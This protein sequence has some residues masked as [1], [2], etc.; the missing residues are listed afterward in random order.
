M[1]LCYNVKSLTSIFQVT[2]IVRVCQNSEKYRTVGNIRG[3]FSKISLEAN[4]R[5]YKYLWLAVSKLFFTWIYST[6]FQYMEYGVIDEDFGSSTGLEIVVKAL[7][8]PLI[9]F[10][11]WV[12][13][14]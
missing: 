7:H 14:G 11:V 4:I 13:R 5:G 6:N 1:F 2:A 10:Y 3:I 8:G 9:S 12:V